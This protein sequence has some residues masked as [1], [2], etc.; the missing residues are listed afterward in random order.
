MAGASWE[1]GGFGDDAGQ[2]N[3]RSAASR[4]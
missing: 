4:C 1:L 2:A 3:I